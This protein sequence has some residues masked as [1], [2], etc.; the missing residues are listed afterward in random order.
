M[1]YSLPFTELEVAGAATRVAV[2]LAPP[3]Y[4][5][6][7]LVTAGRRN[8]SVFSVNLFDHPWLLLAAFASIALG[9]AT[10]RLGPGRATCLGRLIR[11]VLFMAIPLVV[12]LCLPCPADHPI[13]D[14]GVGA[15]TAR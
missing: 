4:V 8:N 15:V 7:G 2:V 10:F 6:L 11:L 3:S 9:C 12:A 1:S 13:D 14:R 5:V